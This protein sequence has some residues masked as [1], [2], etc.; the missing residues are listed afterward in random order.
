[1]RGLVAVVALAACGGPRRLSNPAVEGTEQDRHAIAAVERYRS[2]LEHND[3]AAVTAMAAPTYEDCPTTDRCIDASSLEAALT[4][5]FDGA[6]VAYSMRYE[7]VLHL[8]KR[9]FVDVTID[10]HAIHGDATRTRVVKRDHVRA[11]HTLV[12]DGETYR[13]TKGIL[14]P[15]RSTSA[16]SP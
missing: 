7:R 9:V 13:I 4:G 16:R 2:A 11:A 10:L 12:L 5:R 6:W 8:G 14:P 3:F 1:M 15:S